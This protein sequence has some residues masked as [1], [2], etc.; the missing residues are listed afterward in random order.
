MKAHFPRP[1]Q[2]HPRHSGRPATLV[3]EKRLHPHFEQGPFGECPHDP[4]HLVAEECRILD[5]DAPAD[6]RQAVGEKIPIAVG[7][8]LPNTWRWR[9]HGLAVRRQEHRIVKSSATEQKTDPVRLVELC[10]RSRAAE[11]GSDRASFP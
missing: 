10:P 5:T 9:E 3:G 8:C 4:V 2:C 1:L 7:S 6:I 11:V